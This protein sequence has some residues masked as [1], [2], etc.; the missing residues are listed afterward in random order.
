M[1]EHVYQLCH[2]EVKSEEDYVCHCDVF[3]E[4]RGRYHYFK[5]SFGPLRKVVEYED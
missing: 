2:L 4:I 3:Y 5:Q 1:E